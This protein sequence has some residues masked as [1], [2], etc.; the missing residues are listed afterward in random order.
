MAVKTF[1]AGESANAADTNTYLANAGLVFVKQQTV[2]SGV[3]TATVSDAFSST[4]DNYRIIYSGGSG[5][6]TTGLGVR[7]GGITTNYSHMLFWA[8][9]GA[10][11]PN[12]DA[13]NNTGAQASYMGA[14]SPNGNFL[15]IDVITPFLAKHTGFISHGGYIASDFGQCVARHNLATSYSSF[16]V[17]ALSGTLT[18]GNIC[19]YGYRQ[20]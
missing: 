17:V 19:I 2:G 6:V 9:F 15:S 18:G 10:P 20:A 7:V 4:Y 16:T 8:S 12:I 14:M 5:S 13:A 3:A 1:T 11:T